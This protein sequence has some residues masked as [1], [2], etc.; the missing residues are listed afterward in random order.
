M[1]IEALLWIG[2]FVCVSQLAMFSRLNLAFFSL[3]RLQLELEAKNGSK[4]AERILELRQDSNFLLATLLWGNVGINVLLTLLS[5][6]ALAGITAFVFSTVFIT[7]FGDIIPQAYFSRNTLKMAPI[8]GPR[9]KN[10]S[11]TAIPGRE[12]QRTP[13]GC[14]VR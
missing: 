13:S 3:S 4:I 8:L 12:T 5:D 14:M 1:T 2:I 9:F 11:N 6:A 7:I 10:L